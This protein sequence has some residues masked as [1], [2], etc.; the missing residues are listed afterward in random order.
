MRGRLMTFEC[1]P[2]TDSKR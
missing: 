1:R 2:E